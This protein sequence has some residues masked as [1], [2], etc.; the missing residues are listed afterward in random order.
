MSPGMSP[1][2]G[3]G[4]SPGV[5]PAATPP[6]R[7]RVATKWVALGLLAVTLVLAGFVSYYASNS[8]DGLNRVALDNGFS[9]TQQEH[10]SADSPL[11]GYSSAGVDNQRVSG[12]LAGVA[13]VLVV[14]VLAGG[15][16]F[17]VRRRA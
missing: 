11:A 10:A 7:R 17:V 4:D 3:P 9:N 14:L 5:S 8:P 15:L 12:G 16:T 6:P 13:G 1:G 2:M